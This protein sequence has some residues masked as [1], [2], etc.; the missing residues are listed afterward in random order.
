MRGNPKLLRSALVLLVGAVVYLL[1]DHLPDLEEPGVRP[2]GAERP[3]APPS[4]PDLVPA[5][6][7]GNRPPTT[8]PDSA[9]PPA[10]DGAFSGYERFSD[11]RYLERDG[12]DGDSFRVRAGGREFDLR[13][14]FVDAPE[15]YLSDRYESQR[16]RVADQAREL[17]GIS[18]DEA[19]EVGKRAAAYVRQQLAGRAFTVHTYWEPVFDSE[20]RYAFVELPDG[21][22]LGERLVEQGLA[23][24][25][26]KGPGSKQAPVPTPRGESFS[27][28]RSKLAALE[29]EARAAKRGAWGY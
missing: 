8:P 6:A 4:G 2:P 16:R 10:S 13:L 15:S 14:Y 27:K 7:S 23:R 9:A 29:R 25:H 17:G 20:R 24:I 5:P 11:A 21:G 26:T 18:A 12:N 19:V 1:R 28:A 22:D 3:G